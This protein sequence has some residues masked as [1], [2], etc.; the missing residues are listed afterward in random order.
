MIPY[1][2]KCVQNGNRILNLH[3]RR[4]TRFL[5][6]FDEAISL[7]LKAL[8]GPPG[9]IW[10]KKA[11]SVYI[12]S[13]ITA[14]GCEAKETGLQSGEK[15]HESLLTVEEQFRAYENDDN[16]IVLPPRTFDTEIKYDI[17][18]RMPVTHVYSSDNNTFLDVN[19]IKARMATYD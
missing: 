13:I 19:Q 6:N 1:F 8:E 10:I 15:L 17:S 16:I 12:S 18:G 14:L 3:D 2:R 4:C 11:P 9:L 7:L 5:L